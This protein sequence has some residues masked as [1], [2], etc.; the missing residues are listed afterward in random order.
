MSSFLAFV[1]DICV[2]LS[3]FLCAP[4]SA[5][6]HKNTFSIDGTQN[7]FRY[8]IVENALLG[9]HSGKVIL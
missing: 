6:V 1:S 9:T 4:F 7:R 5:F 2:V 3:L 8:H